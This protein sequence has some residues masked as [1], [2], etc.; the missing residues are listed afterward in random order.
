MSISLLDQIIQYTI[1]MY[2]DSRLQHQSIYIQKKPSQVIL[3]APKL[4]HYI[5]T[6][7]GKKMQDERE[8]NKN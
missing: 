8:K 2:I 7:M 6:L 3:I 4:I 5:L 1:F